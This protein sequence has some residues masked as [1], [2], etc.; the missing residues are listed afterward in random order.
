LAYRY[1]NG[2]DSR[3]F[4]AANF[5][6]K[7]YYHT[8]HSLSSKIN[9]HIFVQNPTGTTKD[10]NCHSSTIWKG[11]INSNPDTGYATRSCLTEVLNLCAK[12]NM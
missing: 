12:P 9:N 6:E 11:S 4:S 10:H 3:Q 5:E 2:V 1:G 7:L 8:S